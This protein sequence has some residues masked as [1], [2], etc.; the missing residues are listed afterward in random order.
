MTAVNL[1]AYLKWVQ[2]ESLSFKHMPMD[3]RLLEINVNVTR[4][5]PAQ[6]LYI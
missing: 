1:N 2:I 4:V 5:T 3:I 6:Q